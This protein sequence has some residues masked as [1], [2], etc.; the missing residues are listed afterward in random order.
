MM[1]PFD[2]EQM[3]QIDTIKKAMQQDFQ[4]LGFEHKPEQV[5][6]LMALEY[7]LAFTSEIISIKN[8]GDNL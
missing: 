1:V 8:T 4:K 7:A 6:D 2:H 5:N 3:A